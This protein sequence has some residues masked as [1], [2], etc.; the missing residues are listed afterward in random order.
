MN[1]HGGVFSTKKGRPSVAYC[2]SSHY[3]IRENSPHKGYA[4][5]NDRLH[6]M[7]IYDL[8]PNHTGLQ[9]TSLCKYIRFI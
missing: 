2:Q 1:E 6:L 9:Q 8:A 7:P 5:S 3:N 4:G